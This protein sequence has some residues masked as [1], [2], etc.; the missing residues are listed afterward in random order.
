[1]LIN[2]TPTSIAAFASVPTLKTSTTK[3]LQSRPVKSSPK[4]KP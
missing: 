3:K 2:E 1:V 4:L